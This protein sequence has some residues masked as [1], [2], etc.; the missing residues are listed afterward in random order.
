MYEFTRPPNPSIILVVR[1]SSFQIDIYGKCGAA[2][3]SLLR[4]RCLV[5]C[6]LQAWCLDSRS[7]IAHTHKAS[8]LVRL[9]A[10]TYW[11]YSITFD[12]FLNA[13]FLIS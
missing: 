6:V 9:F 7:C 10:A 5:L 8:A 13:M 3:F 4:M 11:P 2:L 12:F 1:A